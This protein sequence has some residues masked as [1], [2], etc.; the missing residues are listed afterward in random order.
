VIEGLMITKDFTMS[1]N[2]YVVF[3]CVIIIIL[4][5]T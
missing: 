5:H 2:C 4:V 3:E 1:N